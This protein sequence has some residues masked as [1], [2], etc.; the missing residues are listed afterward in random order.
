MEDAT[1]ISD[2]KTYDEVGLIGKC[3]DEIL[4][5]N[6]VSQILGAIGYEVVGDVGNGDTNIFG[7]YALLAGKENIIK[8]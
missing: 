2:V 6:D 8:K 7:F 3:G 1:Y 5:T 4:D